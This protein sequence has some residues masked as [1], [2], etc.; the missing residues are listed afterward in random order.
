MSWFT[1][2]SGAAFVAILLTVMAEDTWSWATVAKIWIIFF[3]VLGA[4][5]IRLFQIAGEGK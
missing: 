2:F 5:G 3:I 1:M 4:A